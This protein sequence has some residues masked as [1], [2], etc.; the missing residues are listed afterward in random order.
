MSSLGPNYSFKHAWLLCVVVSNQFQ[1]NLLCPV[2]V[3]VPFYLDF[4]IVVEVV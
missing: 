1:I 2:E 3:F 4:H